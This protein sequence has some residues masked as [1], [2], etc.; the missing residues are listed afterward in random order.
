MSNC[1]IGL[2]NLTKWVPYNEYIGDYSCND[3]HLVLI[4]E[5][6]KDIP[7]FED[8]Y[9]ISTFGRIVS[10]SQTVNSRF[11]TRLRSGKLLKAFEDEK[12]YNRIELC[13]SNKLTKK[14]FVHRLVGLTFIDNIFNKPEINHRNGIHNYNIVYNL[15]WSTRSENEI[16]SYKI[17]GKQTAKGEING[18]SIITEKIAELIKNSTE[19]S[20]VL[21]ERLGIKQNTITVI[22]SGK[23]WKHLNN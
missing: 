2:Q 4:T 17:L 7:G 13:D 15:E 22:K 20:V 9:Q 5:D 18:Q 23:R 19:K 8:R 6:W 3:T 14:H 12:G 1:I 16:H 21:A 10:Y 11:K